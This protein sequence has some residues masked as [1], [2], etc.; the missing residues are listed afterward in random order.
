MKATS[1]EAK[2]I[3]SFIKETRIDMERSRKKWEQERE[4]SRIEREKAQEQSRKKWEIER[5]KVQKKWDKDMQE[6]RKSQ[7]ETI[8]GL[9]KAKELFETQ[10]GKL[11]ESLVEGDLV[12]LLNKKG[13]QLNSSSTRM[14]GEY[15]GQAWEFDI[16]AVNGK[17]VVIVEV[18]TTLRVK[19]IEYF[20]KKLKSFT[21]WRPEYKGKII[22]GSV[23]YLRSDE[24]SV[25]Y[26]ER[27][28]LFVIKA[29]G[30]SSSIIN[31]KKFKPK[32]FS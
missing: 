18:K 29:T 19:D 4:Q 8:K 26:A 15:K 31:Q 16:I 5:E 30:S 9:Q 12:T 2:E 23:A 14:Q 27:Q 17:E 6:L 32:V 10:W 22:Y 20:L 7:R 11:M 25:K 28:G 3:W 13:I 1:P 24:Y 21:T